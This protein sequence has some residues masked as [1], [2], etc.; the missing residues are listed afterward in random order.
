VKHW[1][2]GGETK[3]SNLV[4]LCSFHHRLV[5]EGDYGLT[6]TNDGLFIF[7]R[8]DGRRVPENGEICFRGNNSPPAPAYP[9]FEETLRI[10]MLNREKGLAI[11]A[12]T[13]RC[14][15]LGE[16]MDYSMAIEGMQFLEAKASPISPA[17]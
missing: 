17:T 6:A 13:G 2:D 11:T 4:T 10:Y 9:G 1:A 12:E 5:H 8:P 3:L 15:W 14:Q 16:R 7:T